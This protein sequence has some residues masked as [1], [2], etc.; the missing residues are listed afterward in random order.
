L[1]KVTAPFWDEIKVT[2][3][4]DFSNA[5]Q[6]AVPLDV[7]GGGEKKKDTVCRKMTRHRIEK[8]SQKRGGGGKYA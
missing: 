3:W 8:K 6:H 7:K 2:E 1:L 5:Y 4:T